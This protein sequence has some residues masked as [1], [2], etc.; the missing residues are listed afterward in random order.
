MTKLKY[1][2]L[3][4]LL[5]SNLALS[6][7][8]ALCCGMH[9]PKT[10]LTV[11]I[12]VGANITLTGPIAYWGQQ[13]KKGLDLAV[14]EANRNKPVRPIELVYQDNQG[15]AKNAIGIFQ[16]F[17][18]VDNVSAVISIFTPVSKPLRSIAAQSKVPL[19]ATVVSSVGFG[20]E[21]EWSFRDFPSQTQQATAIAEYAYNQY[22]LKKAATLVVNDD[23]GRDGEEVFT[24]TFT[25][26]GGTVV[27]KD[28]VDQKATDIRSQLQKLLSA[29][30]DVI[31]MVVRDSTLGMAVKQ[32]RELRFT[33]KIIGV[34]AF[35]APVVWEAAGNAGNGV[36]FTS[37]YIDF[38]GNSEA[39]DFGVT[40]RM[41]YKEEPDWV[42]VYG[43][44]IGKYI[45]EIA[46]ESNGDATALRDK[47]AN[48]HVDSIRGELRM[49][50]SRDVVSPIAIY[51]R[52]DGI[53]VFL[54][55]ILP[56]E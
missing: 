36:I 35:D 25:K 29:K 17:T 22:A 27:A 47:L 19:L 30:P 2:F 8:L 18:S 41:A 46:S 20:L 15:E 54:K 55:K 1:Y 32:A 9:N 43:Y 49:N 52:K 40:Y 39:K 12:K 4:F 50:T 5:S 48:M 38:E 31:F 16:R 11:P 44:T 28:T 23:Y 24:Q 13:V 21:N 51:Q 53:N 45:F 14:S 56:T 42:S 10:P 3:V 26:L 33:G 6:T 34:N 7:Y 37:A